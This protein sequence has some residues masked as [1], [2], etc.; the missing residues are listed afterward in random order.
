[1]HACFR[2]EADLRTA[3]A[4]DLRHCCAGLSL[5]RYLGAIESLLLLGSWSPQALL[6]RVDKVSYRGGL[7][8]AR[9]PSCFAASFSGWTRLFPL[10]VDA[11]TAASRD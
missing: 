3:L 11:K 6:A 5:L 7:G 1:M 4:R 10:L 2:P 9:P 8:R